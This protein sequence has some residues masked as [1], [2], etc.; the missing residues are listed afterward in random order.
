MIGPCR[1]LTTRIRPLLSGLS[2][3][4]QRRGCSRRTARRFTSAAVL[5]TFSFASPSG[6]SATGEAFELV[7]GNAA[8]GTYQAKVPFEHL[9]EAGSWNATVVLADAVGNSVKRSPG[10]L[11]EALESQTELVLAIGDAHVEAH[12]GAFQGRGLLVEVGDELPIAVIRLVD[13]VRL[14]L[15]LAQ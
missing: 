3:C 4:S 11:Q 7:A 14:R 8:N 1:T 6:E 13:Q 15:H 12:C 10:D 2:G 5:W 9:S